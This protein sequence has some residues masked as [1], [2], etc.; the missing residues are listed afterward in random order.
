MVISGHSVTLNLFGSLTSFSFSFA[1]A[2]DSIKDHATDMESLRVEAGQKSTQ[3][4]NLEAMIESMKMT[5]QQKNDEIEQLKASLASSE[6][7]R[8]KADK[9]IQEIAAENQQLTKDMDN[10]L[11]QIKEF[12]EEVRTTYALHSLPF[13]CLDTCP[14][15]I[16]RILLLIIL[17]LYRFKA[18][19]LQR[20]SW[21]KS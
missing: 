2:K 18:R 12:M 1:I 6:E 15:L 10:N 20:S 16:I 19:M 17:H 5:L 3:I 13:I 8:I 21:K 7:N 9:A 4:A 14:C 11:E